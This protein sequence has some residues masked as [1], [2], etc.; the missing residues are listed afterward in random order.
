[1]LTHGE[2][3]SRVA[4]WVVAFNRGSLDL[5]DGLLHRDAVFRLNGVAYEDTLGRP[6]SDPLVRL[7]ARG[8]G[9]YR[10]LAK[11]LQYALGTPEVALRDFEIQR[12]LATGY[13][14]LTGEL[15]DSGEAWEATA[16]I[17][18]TV[19]IEGRV[20]ELA[21]QMASSSVARLQQARQG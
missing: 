21:V 1:M 4:E 17:A 5:P 6:A 19:D 8:P 10:L 14:D 13:A 7:V 11:G 12:G 18:M 2:F 9:G 20:T 16:D 15:R 3:V